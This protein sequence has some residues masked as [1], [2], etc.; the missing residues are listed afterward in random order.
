MVVCSVQKVFSF[1]NTSLSLS[2]IRPNS[3]SDWAFIFRITS[4][5]WIFT[6]PRQ[7]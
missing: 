6:A 1:A 7:C 4:M 2:A 5:R 3:G